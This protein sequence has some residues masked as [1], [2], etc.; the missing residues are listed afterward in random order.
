MVTRIRPYNPSVN[1]MVSDWHVI[2]A[3][4]KVLGR[5]ATQIATLLMGKHKPGYVPH[6]MSGDF[7]VVINA[8]EVVVTGKKAEQIVYRRHSQRPGHLKEIPYLRYQAKFPERVIEHSVRG[9]LPKNKLGDRMI[10]RLKVYAGEEHPH[11]AQVIGSER[12]PEREAAIAAK[13]EE[14]ARN[15][16]GR[17]QRAQARAEIAADAAAGRATEDTESG[18]DEAE[19]KTPTRRRSSSSRTTTSSTARSGSRR[20]SASTT[21][22]KPKATTSRRRSTTA[23]SRATSRKSSEDAPAKAPARSRRTSRKDESGDK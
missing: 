15:A 23:G 9:M 7:V 21:E 12:R 20:S 18:A 5:L 16:A 1:D 2:D 3:R 4:G 10:T 19:E 11:A 22:E 14:E 17:R 6:L 8:S 13:T